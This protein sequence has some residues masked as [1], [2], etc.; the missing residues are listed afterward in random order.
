MILISV[1]LFSA[2]NT[3]TANSSLLT[4]TIPELANS[5]LR[6]TNF[7]GSVPL[8]RNEIRHKSEIEIEVKHEKQQR[9][10]KNTNNNNNNT[11]P[12][13]T[14]SYPSVSRPTPVLNKRTPTL[15][16]DEQQYPPTRRRIL[17]NS[18]QTQTPPLQI[19]SHEQQLKALTDESLS[20]NEKIQAILRELNDC[21][22]RRTC[23]IRFCFILHL[24]LY[25]L[26]TIIKQQ[27]QQ[28]A[29]SKKDRDQLC[30]IVDERTNEIR[31]LKQKNEQFEQI[32]R[33]G[34]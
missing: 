11:S 28:L 21:Q 24:L 30:F 15:T 12:S 8:S 9:Q 14:S 19:N 7:T 32:I 33:N 3:P 27:E 1:V 31:N 29:N 16:Y 13:S 26:Q 6:S 20:K 34:R 25:F 17:T 5:V 18:I 23:R 2:P 4:P 10:L 22:V